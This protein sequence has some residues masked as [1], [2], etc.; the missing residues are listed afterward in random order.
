VLVIMDVT[1]RFDPRDQFALDLLKQSGTKA[2]LIL[3]KVDLLR[4][5]RSFCR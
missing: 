5:N 4:D 1:R 3:N 2:F